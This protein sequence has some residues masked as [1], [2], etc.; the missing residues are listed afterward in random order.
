MGK[1]TIAQKERWALDLLTLDKIGAWAIT[2]PNSGLRRVRLDDVDRPPGRRR[3]RAERLQDLHHQRPLRRHDRVHLQARRGQRRRR[4][5]RSCSSCSTRACPAWSS[6]SRCARWASTPAR[7]ASSSSTTCASAWTACSASREAY[8][9]KGGRDASKATFSHGA[10][11]RG[12]HGARHRRALP[13]AVDRVRQRPRAVR[14][15]DRQVPAHPAEA[16]QDGGRPHEPPEPRVPPHRDVGRGCRHELRR[17]L[18]RQALRG[19]GRDRRGAR[20]GAALRRQ[21]LHGRVRG[22]AARPR[23]EGAAD[24]RRHR[25]DP[26]LR[27]RPVAARRPRRHRA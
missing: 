27:G 1:G 17:G 16:R 24:L 20:G 9:G 6:P 10:H 15:A 21:R 12:R 3:V 19:A 4:S 2:E 23:R 22:R 26:G 13:R 25:R 18:R 11:R 5:A 8:G 14:P 7:R